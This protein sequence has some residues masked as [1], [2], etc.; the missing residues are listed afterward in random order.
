MVGLRSKVGEQPKIL[1]FFRVNR[2]GKRGEEE[3][4]SQEAKE[5]MGFAE[6]GDKK[7]D[8]EL[9]E[10]KSF[11]KETT[12]SKSSSESYYSKPSN[13]SIHSKPSNESIHLNPSNES[14]HSNHSN[15]SIHSKPSQHHPLDAKDQNHT[16]T[17]EETSAEWSCDRCTFRNQ[18]HDKFC[19]VCGFSRARYSQNESMI[20]ALFK[21]K[22]ART[23][24]RCTV[25]GL[26]C[27]RHQVQKE[28]KNKG[29]FFYVCSLPIGFR[30]DPKA[31]CNYFQWEDSCIVC[32]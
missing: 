25:H 12:S 10:V 32:S 23:I 30:N 16:Q 28:G 29:R 20:D 2:G 3:K 31:K 15:E 5:R 4:S 13:E 26:P 19:A 24:P 17:K 22:K 6:C 21:G 18:P 11:R 14:I 8:A 27:V 9:K 7:Q 1:S